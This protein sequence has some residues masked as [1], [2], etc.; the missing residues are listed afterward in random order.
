MAAPG[1]MA[2]PSLRLWPVF[3]LG[4]A[5]ASLSPGALQPSAQPCEQCTDE[6]TSYMVSQ[7]ITC[8][9]E[10]T[11]AQPAHCKTWWPEDKY[12]QQAC[13]DA[14]H[15]YVHCCNSTSISA[16]LRTMARFTDFASNDAVV[17]AAK[18]FL[19]EHD[20]TLKTKAFDS[21]AALLRK[22]STLQPRLLV[23]DGCSGSS[24][25]VSLIKD[26]MK[27]H[28]HRLYGLPDEL[29]KC[30]KNPY[31]N[32]YDHSAGHETF[33]MQTAV[34]HTASYGKSLVVKVQGGDTNG[35]REAMR[36]MGA[37]ALVAYRSNTLAKLLCDVRDCF[38]HNGGAI[39]KLTKRMGPNANAC[40][41]RRKLPSSRQTKVWIDPKK[42][43]LLKELKRLD[44]ENEEMSAMLTNAGYGHN[45]FAVVTTEALFE[46]ETDGSDAA[47]HRT[48]GA[49]MKAL[50]SLGVKPDKAKI[51]A[52]LEPA[53][54]GRPPSNIS[55]TITNADEVA[56]AL[57]ASSDAQYAQMIGSAPTS[58]F[59][60]FERF[61]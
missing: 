52:V 23:S 5:S 22:S 33:A 56:A 32:T 6:P 17:E 29:F 7:G 39:T 11:S 59:E 34:A 55:E 26:M 35:P 30:E 31:C 61:D 19:K 47:F 50:K 58:V 20:H 25:A 27:A 57:A 28:G 37:Y 53:R 51:E 21:F 1:R 44:N 13:F 46:S 43:R 9:Q 12:C 4:W 8:Q 60:D 14:G 41:N 3:L 10:V 38:E 45:D 18:A 42:G 54:G 48:T 40:F 24:A 16:S 15:G 2:A 49:W 36:E